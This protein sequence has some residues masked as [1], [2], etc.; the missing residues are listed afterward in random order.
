MKWYKSESTIIPDEVDVIS[1]KKVVYLRR[2]I[3][4]KQKESKDIDKQYTYFEYDEA[5]L[6]K[7]E[8]TEYLKGLAV[9][10]IQQQRADIDY[11]SIMTGIEL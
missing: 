6:T 11:L 5:K 2:N 4:E 1:S 3:V 9:I 10:D 8:Y 7:D